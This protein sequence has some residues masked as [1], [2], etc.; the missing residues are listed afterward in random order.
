MFDIESRVGG[1]LRVQGS[2][3]AITTNVSHAGKGMNDAE[4]G[5]V[6]FCGRFSNHANSTKYEHDQY[7]E[8]DDLA[9]TT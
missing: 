4:K 1:S 6:R 2:I 7:D 9:S 8:Y 5:V 3:P